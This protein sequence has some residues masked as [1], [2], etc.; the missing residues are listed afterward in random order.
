MLCRNYI[1][2]GLIYH[3]PFA[4]DHQFISAVEL[5]KKSL[6]ESLVYFY[7]L[8]GRLIT[9]SDGVLYIDCNDAGA[10][11]IEASAADVGIQEITEVE[12][13]PVVPQF[14]ALDGAINLNGHFLPLLVVQVTKLRDGMVIGF[15]INHAVVDGTSFWHF[16]NSL[17][18]LCRGAATV[19][20]LPLHSRCFDIEGSRISLNLPQTLAIDKFSPPVLSEKIFHFSKETIRSLKDRANKKNSEGQIIISSFQAHFAHVWQAITRARGLA[21]HEPTTLR[22]SVNC[23]PRLIPP[24]PRTYFGNAIQVVS[25]TVTAGEL[26]NCDIFSAAG[27]LHRIIWPHRDATIRGKLQSYNENPT[28]F[29]MDGTIRDNSV[30]MGSS[31]SFPMYDNDFGWGRPVGARSGWANK[32][33]GKVSAYP[34]KKE[35]SVDLEICLL[36]P[37]MAALD[38]DPHFLVAGE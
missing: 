25:T 4:D 9:S 29:K 6:S 3:M 22:F 38:T 18:E 36:P 34:G 8:A 37:F 27:L 1:Q 28:V 15:T 7:P 19:S 35:G 17:A 20:H 33:D 14:F 5:L 16:I 21:P 24:L 31:S 2:K 10:D 13:R 32:F 11:F 30:M 23:R 26:L 12:V